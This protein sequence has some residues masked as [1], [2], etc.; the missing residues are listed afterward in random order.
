MCCKICLEVNLVEDEDTRSKSK[1]EYDIKNFKV[2][3]CKCKGSCEFV[4]FFCLQN[5]LESKISK[6]T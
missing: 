1:E 3:P 2:T 5:W 4:H 6:K